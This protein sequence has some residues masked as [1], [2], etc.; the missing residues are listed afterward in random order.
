M[1]SA[2]ITWCWNH[3][4][5]TIVA[6][7]LLGGW[8]AY[9]LINIKVDAI[10]D[11]SET[12]VII[13]SEWMGRSPDLVEAQI[14][15]PLV[16]TLLSAP[17]VKVARGFS[18]FGM[19]FVYVIFEDGTDNYWARARVLEYLSKISGQMPEG[20]TPSIGPDASGVGWVLQYALVDPEGKYNLAQIK[21]FQDWYL[22]YWLSAVP[23]V[24]EVASVGG[25][26]KQYQVEVDPNKLAALNLSLERVIS[27][28]RKSNNDVGGRTLEI[29]EREY[30]IRGLGY[31]KDPRDLE[32]IALG[33]SAD[34]TPILLTDVARVTLGPNIRRGI[35]DLNGQG[36]TVGGVV[37]MRQG[38]D[39]SRVIAAVKEKIATVK[40][41]F[42]PGL[43]LQLVYDRSDLIGQAVQTLKVNLIEEIIL[44]CIVILFFLFHIRSILVVVITLPLSLLLSLIPM[45]YFDISL[46][47]MSLGG[48][49]LAVGDIVDGVVVF[50]ENTH[51]KIANSDGKKTRQELAL[52]ACREL[53]PAIFSALLIISISFLPI[54][55]LQAQ[56][57]KLFHPLAYTKTFAMLAAALVTIT[58]VPILIALFV[59]GRIRKASDNPL[60]RWLQAIYTPVVSWAVAHTKTVFA[61]TA[62]LMAVSAALFLRLGSE[63]MPPL[64]EGDL[65]YMPITVPGISVTAAQDILTRQNLAIKAI[66]EVV[67]SF[68]KAGRFETATDPAPLSMFEYTIRLK[69]QK[70]WRAGLTPEALVQELDAAVAVPGL[71]RA[72]TK[73]VRGRID[74]LSTGIRTPVGIKIFGP[75]LNTI[76]H[77]G[78]QIEQTLAKLPGTRSAYAE[79]IN[80]GNYLDFEADKAALAR[81]G[82]VLGDVQMVIETAIGGMDIAETVEGRER[83]SINVRYPR[84][85]RDSVEKIEHI[86][87]ATPAG[88]QVPL[89]Q[90]GKLITRTGP[91]MVLDENGSLAGYVYIDLLNRDAGGYVTDA[92]AAIADAVHIPPGYFITWTGQYE[93]LARMQKRMAIV[94]PVTLALVFAFLY[95]SMQS[96]S[97]AL[98]VM[99]AVP[100][101]LSG[102]IILMWFLNYNTSVAVW[103]GAIAL[104]GVAVS[105]TSIMMVFLDQS[106]RRWQTEG[107]LLTASDG[108]LAIV[109]GA[110]NS[111]RSVLMAVA[112]NVFGLMP[113][114]LA[115][116]LGADVMKTLASPM[117]GG[118][119]S[120]IFLTL[121]V[122][123]CV[124]RRVYGHNLPVAENNAQP[125][126]VL[127]P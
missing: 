25:F 57:G 104:I 102:G 87:V 83:Y 97:K 127:T 70:E 16:S 8:G 42:P 67:S 72:W 2:I 58:L 33:V 5:A 68:G 77:I 3:S 51:T 84:E 9:C 71:N 17:K 89:S 95:F 52:E 6:A 122:I 28:I 86:L 125:V 107:R 13:F 75:D 12:Q 121:L 109:E 99:L 74:M 114:M 54:F 43:E 14:T 118:L 112:M 36:D 31:V 88:A 94:L 108:Q 92:K 80:G 24:A 66:P 90:L 4:K 116:G 126:P 96:T 41:A 18:M 119:L 124:Y 76:E 49:I 20:V 34:A 7:L 44:V 15:Y 93:Y 123:P 63:F 23:G 47:I 117:F 60:N 10:P 39:V 110:K 59:K 85:L 82:L 103:A 115:T 105:T 40:G 27:A 1:I 26:D 65:L 46:N 64:W 35:S 45:Y 30:Y 22:K 98:I 101:S 56:E 11:L 78:Q 106:W 48:I 29:S 120:L 21:T 73:P 81:Y 37:V 50:I 62:L 100:L 113:V 61:S 111:L 55:A 69:P 19:S 79:R 38:E 53:G 91:P 32:N